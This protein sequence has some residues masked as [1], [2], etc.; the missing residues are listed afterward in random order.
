MRENPARPTRR[1][2]TFT[3]PFRTISIVRSIVV[4]GSPTDKMSLWGKT[5]RPFLF[6]DPTAAD[7]SARKPIR[8]QIS[9]SSTPARSRRPYT[10]T[11]SIV[12]IITVVGYYSYCHYHRR[13]T[14]PPPPPRLPT[15]YA[16]RR[17]SGGHISCAFHVVRSTGADDPY[18]T[19]FFEYCAPGHVVQWTGQRSYC[20]LLLYYTR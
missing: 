8:E 16:D 15:P 2:S 12:V 10:R 4:V 14:P 3:S 13:R 18:Q 1:R 17:Q 7:R 5:R 9:G 19:E 11:D 20:P 6:P